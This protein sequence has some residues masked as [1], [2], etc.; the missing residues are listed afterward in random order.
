[1]FRPIEVRPL[2]HFR[3]FLRYQDGVEGEADLSDLAGRG[4]FGIWNVPGEFDK[5][6]IGE[7]G[8][9]RWS[10]E[11]D[12]CPDS[13]YMRLSGKSPEEV[14]PSLRRQTREALP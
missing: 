2:P 3:I 6:A 7:S 14:F 12:L 8:E 5:A 10:D 1:M 11:V 13:L 4:V 9:I